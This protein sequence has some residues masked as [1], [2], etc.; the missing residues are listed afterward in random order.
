MKFLFL[1]VIPAEIIASI[2]LGKLVGGWMLLLWFVIAFFVG[3]QLMRG[4]GQ[5]LTPQMQRAQ[6]G[7]APDVNDAF[8]A[9]LSQALAGILFI[10]PGVVTDILGTLLLLPPIQKVVGKQMQAAFAQRGANFFMAGGGFGGMG[11]M[12]QGGFGQSPFGQNPFGQQQSPFGRHSDVFEGEARE[13]N[14]EPPK[15]IEDKNN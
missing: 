8:L 6:Q 15:R 10:I 9:G 13:V 5:V 2:W 1:L 3:R 12:P 4:A 11:G 14:P 7:M